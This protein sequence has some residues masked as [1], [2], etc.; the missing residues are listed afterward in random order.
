MRRLIMCGMLAALLAPLPG[1]T[2][3]Q[4]SLDDMIQ[5]STSIVR[6]KAQQTSSAFHGSVIYTYYTI[7]VSENLK[8][9]AAHQLEFGVP[10]GTSNGM[11]QAVSGAPVLTPGK[12]YV[13]FLWTGKSGLT[14]VI[15]LSQGLFA[16]TA[17]ANGVLQVVR[18]AASERMLNSSGQA[19]S[20]SDIQMT[21]SALRTRIQNVL[22][23][24][25]Q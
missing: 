5:R 21:L 20:D 12:D 16:V 7:Q 2:L 22:S 13:L 17:D 14:Q 9:P 1:S 19:V 25:G 24:G 3:I 6:G 10:G 23:G 11:Q 15:G 18:A 4:L 8:G